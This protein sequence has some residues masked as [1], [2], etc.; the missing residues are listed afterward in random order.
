MNFYRCVKS[1]RYALKGIAWVAKENNFRIHMLATAAVVLAG[2]GTGLGLS[3]WLWIV[4]AVF[5]VLV[6][7]TIN[8]A[9]EKLTDLVSPEHNLL[10]GQVKDLGAGAVLLSAVYAVLVAA[11]IFIPEW[12]AACL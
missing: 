12:M 4:S 5:M 10:A 8:T 2:W 1:F 7:E 9:L 6:A 11:L 3:Q